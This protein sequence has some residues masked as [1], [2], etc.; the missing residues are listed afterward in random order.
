M[1]ST[2][3]AAGLD[4]VRKVILSESATFNFGNNAATINGNARFQFPLKVRV[5][6]YVKYTLTYTAHKH[7]HQ[8]HAHSQF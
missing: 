6:V 2:N 7:T 8:L 3:I 4:D 1:L 5:Y